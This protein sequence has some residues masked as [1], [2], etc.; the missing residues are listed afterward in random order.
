MGTALAADV[1]VPPLPPM[2][3]LAFHRRLSQ[4]YFCSDASHGGFVDGSWVGYQTYS[5]CTT[6][7]EDDCLDFAVTTLQ[8]NGENPADW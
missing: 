4:G 5:S 3:G 8:A 7:S 6:S 1:R 2:A